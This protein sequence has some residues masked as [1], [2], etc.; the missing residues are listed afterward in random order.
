MCPPPPPP[1]PPS[2]FTRKTPSQLRRKEC[3]KKEIAEEAQ[4]EDIENESESVEEIQDTEVKT[5]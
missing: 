2:S 4:A 1:P 3:C 5:S